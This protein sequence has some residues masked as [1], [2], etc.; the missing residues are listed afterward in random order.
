MGIIWA[1]FYDADKPPYVEVT[2]DKIEGER[3]E[4]YLYM[5]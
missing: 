1:V 5:H 3:P 2:H 4:T